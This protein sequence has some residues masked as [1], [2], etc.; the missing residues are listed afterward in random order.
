M[1]YWFVQLCRYTSS[2]MI[3]AIMTLEDCPEVV[4]YGT[5]ESIKA[6]L[7]SSLSS[8]EWIGA[9][10]DILWPFALRQDGVRDTELEG[11]LEKFAKSILGR[12][13]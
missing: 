7:G 11:E 8:S 3:V 4:H 6:L 13:K 10:K 5:I 2:G 9:G 12:Q 1:K